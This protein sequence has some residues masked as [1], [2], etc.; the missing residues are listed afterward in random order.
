MDEQFHVAYARLKDSRTV[1]QFNQC[2]V[3]EHDFIGENL[4]HRVAGQSTELTLEYRTHSRMSTLQRYRSTQTECSLLIRTRSVR[5]TTRACSTRQ[6]GLCYSIARS[7]RINSRRHSN[8]RLTCVVVRH[9]HFREDNLP[10]LDGANG[11]YTELDGQRE[12]KYVS[13][14]ATVTAKPV[15]LLPR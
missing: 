11:F 9:R 5:S 6:V 15:Q 7:M 2:E 10:T 13:P 8:M 3:T 1:L 14:T 4:V 12:R